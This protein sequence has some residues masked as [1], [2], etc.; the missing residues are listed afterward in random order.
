MPQFRYP[1]DGDY[2]WLRTDGG[3]KKLSRIFIDSK[4][5][6]D[7]RGSI[8]VLAEGSHILWV[9]SIGRCSAYYYVTGRTKEVLRAVLCTEGEK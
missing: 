8:W 1:E 5:P 3:K 7:K 6:K 9:P 4:I 2:M